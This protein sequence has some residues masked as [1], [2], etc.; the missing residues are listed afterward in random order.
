MPPP[1][2]E[3]LDLPLGHVLRQASVEEGC[4]RRRP[5]S[6]R[7]F[8][9]SLRR[10][11]TKIAIIASYS[12]SDRVPHGGAPG[13]RGGAD[14]SCRIPAES[15]KSSKARRAGA[16]ARAAVPQG[17]IGQSAGAGAGLEEPQD[18][19]GNLAAPGRGRG[20]GAQGRRAG[21]GGQI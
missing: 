4:G 21:A 20:A 12:V 9:A 6:R 5:T 19:A 11:D 13:A 7:L 17:A 3:A 16:A 8:A 1:L 18:L 2:D 10:D 14:D 15:S